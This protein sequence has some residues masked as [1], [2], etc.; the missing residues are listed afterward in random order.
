MRTDGRTDMTQL[1]VAF[2]NF[3]N[4][5][6][7]EIS[8]EKENVCKQTDFTLRT[9]YCSFSEAVCFSGK[10]MFTKLPKSEK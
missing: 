3:V 2:L 10:I 6:I 4:A 5:P 9:V 7:K 8:G 1:I